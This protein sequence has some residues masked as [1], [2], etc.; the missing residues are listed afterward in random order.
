[1]AKIGALKMLMLNME[2]AA[3]DSAATPRSTCDNGASSSTK[4]ILSPDCEGKNTSLHVQHRPELQTDASADFTKP[5][6][7][8]S[9][10]GILSTRDFEASTG[11]AG[12][13]LGAIAQAVSQV[14][15]EQRTTS[16]A[17]E[18]IR[19][20]LLASGALCDGSAPATR[21]KARAACENPDVL[22]RTRLNPAVHGRRIRIRW[23]QERCVEKAQMKS[24]QAEKPSQ[25]HVSAVKSPSNVQPFKTMSSQCSKD[26]LSYESASDTNFNLP[27]D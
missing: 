21:A 23:H 16:A 10:S 4:Q 8:G 26:T 6:R 27:G 19:A 22:C 7:P 14:L 13:D 20:A 9:G 11:C 5:A 24:L 25:C 3:M 1:V 12:T 15:W 2:Q 18:Q 17:I